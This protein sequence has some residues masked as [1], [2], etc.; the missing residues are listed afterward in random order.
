M[1]LFHLCIAHI[2][3]LYHLLTFIV[4]FSLCF[5][6]LPLHI[7]MTKVFNKSL[8]WISLFSL[9]R[10]FNIFTLMTEEIKI[11]N[12]TFDRRCSYE[13]LKIKSDVIWKKNP[14]EIAWNRIEYDRWKCFKS[15]TGL[16]SKV[17]LL[18]NYIMIKEIRSIGSKF[19]NVFMIKHL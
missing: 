6:F 10:H 15:R 14:S 3:N 4:R 17:F 1:F 9:W 2:K 11:S 7:F 12:S 16:N 13:K 18:C 19:Y 5:I 8:L